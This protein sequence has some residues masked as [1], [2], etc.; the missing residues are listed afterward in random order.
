MSEELP[1]SLDI[2]GRISPDTVWDYIGKMRCSNSKM[3]SLLRLNATNIE[4]KM[5][6]IALYSYLSSRG[7][8]GVVK[9]TNKAVKDFYIFPLGSQ[10][11]IPQAL[12]PI[13][14]P[15]KLHFKYVQ[16]LFFY[17]VFIL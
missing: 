2:V 10:T 15:G 8:L 3:I 7:R 14:G 4:E 11:P 12:L 9:S 5:P 17:C 6:Y 16:A 1:P 13:N